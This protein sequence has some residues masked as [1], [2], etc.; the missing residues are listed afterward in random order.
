MPA[1][2]L[3]EGQEVGSAGRG[4]ST[5]ISGLPTSHWMKATRSGTHGRKGHGA[6]N[7]MLAETKQKHGCD[8]VSGSSQ[9]RLHQTAQDKGSCADLASGCRH[10]PL[11]PESRAGALCQEAQAPG[12]VWELL[13]PFPGSS[14]PQSTEE[15][16]C[17]S[18]FVN[19]A[20]R[21]CLTQTIST[22]HRWN[23]HP[24]FHRKKLEALS[25]AVICGRLRA[26]AGEAGF[27]LKSL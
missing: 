22:P 26:R 11:L 13:A 19:Q 5:G 2:V 27:H 6:N 15:Q 12:G 17:A 7:P 16:P 3:E 18:S 21:W 25:S 1:T 8:S 4:R 10:T 24:I 23:V 14:V 9:D 20:Q